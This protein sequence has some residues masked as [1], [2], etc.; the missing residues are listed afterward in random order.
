MHLHVYASCQ[1]DLPSLSSSLSLPLH[2]SLSLALSFPPLTLNGP[3]SSLQAFR[4]GGARLRVKA[5]SVAMKEAESRALAFQAAQS[6][7]DA[8]TSSPKTMF[9]SVLNA[10]AA[11]VLRVC[12]SVNLMYIAPSPTLAHTPFLRRPEG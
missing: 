8:P 3:H 1:T 6:S 11:L 2:L 5:H 10:A 12:L 9:K 7:P 4:S